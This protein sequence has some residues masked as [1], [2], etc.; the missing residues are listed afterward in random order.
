V[1]SKWQRGM[2][3]QTAYGLTET[4]GPISNHIPDP[5]WK[6]LNL[7]DEEILKIQLPKRLFFKE[8]LDPNN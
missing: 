3:I 8:L 7:S 2:H 5:Y 4:Y 6:E 1:S